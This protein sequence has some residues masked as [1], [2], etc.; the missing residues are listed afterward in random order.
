MGGANLEKGAMTSKT[1][2]KFSSEVRTQAV[3]MVLDHE[4]D[5]A[6]RLAAVVL[7][8]AKIGCTPQRLKR[9]IV[10]EVFTLTAKRNRFSL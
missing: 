9:Y 6:S 7:I 2:S 10:R 5:H 8:A 1:T 3:Q 4:G